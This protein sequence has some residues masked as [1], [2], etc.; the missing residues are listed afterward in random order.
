[1]NDEIRKKIKQKVSDL[2]SKPGVYKMLNEDGKIIYIG[3]A[4]N[5]K[6]RVSSYFRKTNKTDR[7]LKMVY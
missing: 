5:L 2:P 3:K 7:I 6:N 4:K 1:M